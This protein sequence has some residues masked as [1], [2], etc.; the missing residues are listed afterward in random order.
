MYL[1]AC[2]RV[3]VG[4]PV[5]LIPNSFLTQKATMILTV[6]RD[7]TPCILV[8]IFFTIQRICLYP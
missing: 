4:V 6:F 3:R 2:V 5:S 7:V 1:H 8:E